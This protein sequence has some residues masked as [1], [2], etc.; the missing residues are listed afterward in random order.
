MFDR[1]RKDPVS[2]KAHISTAV[3]EALGRRADETMTP[4]AL[5]SG[6][7]ERLAED[8]AGVA[9]AT[10]VRPDAESDVWPTSLSAALSRWR[11]ETRPTSD[12]G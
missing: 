2:T 11:S 10:M 3:E 1:H 9:A 5:G 4:M 12:H 7:D 6:D 8:F